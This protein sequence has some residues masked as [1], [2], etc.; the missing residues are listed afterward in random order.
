MVRAVAVS[1]ALGG[2][3]GLER[4]SHREPES[5]LG[6]VGVRTFALSSLLGTVSVIAQNIL[7]GLPYVVGLGYFALLV[8][9]FWHER[10]ATEHEVGITTQISAMVVFVLGVLVPSMP[11][12]A[13]SIAV[14]VAI[15]L[16]LK[17][18]TTTFVHLLTPAEIVSTMKFLLVT[19]VLLPLLPDQPV[20][21]WGIYNLREIWLLVV[22]I[23][24]ISFLGYFAI[25][26]LGTS[27]G[28]VL[29]GV[30][31]GMASS[32]AVALAMS[33][34]VHQNPRSRTVLL[35]AAFAIMLANAFMFGRVTV[36]VA[37]VNLELVKTLWLPFVLMAIPGSV[38]AGLLWVTL[39]SHVRDRPEGRDEPATLD[40][41][42]TLEIRNPF[43][44]VPALKFALL[45][46][47]IIGV[48]KGLGQ[49]YGS[50]VIY[51]TAIFGGLAETNAISLAVA[52]M[53]AGGELSAALATQAI[54]IAILT[55]SLVKAIMSAIIG[56]R[57]LGAYVAM[58]LAPIMAVGLLAAFLLL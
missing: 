27:R 45:L 46:V 22:L 28:L 44:L 57:R 34:Q 10:R 4:Q 36:A 21:P 51:L 29:T 16:S 48:A 25:R 1:L 32:T 43:E 54:V 18:H 35:S 39:V 14:I 38:V 52:R 37:V 13:A 41:G 19:V 17:R 53:E 20:D 5:P 23:S 55:N 42:M 30:L 33:R 58:G 56:S 12:V 15:V 31:G 8:A 24:G 6:S 9:F 47:V 49:L 11:M 3:I 7:P 26:F 2:I 40:E 50:Q